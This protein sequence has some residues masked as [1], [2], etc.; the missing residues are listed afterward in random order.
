MFKK[1]KLNREY[2]WRKKFVAFTNLD[3]SRFSSVKIADFYIRFVEIYAN[4]TN[5]LIVTKN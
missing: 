5:K 4:G 1:W 2:V 3:S